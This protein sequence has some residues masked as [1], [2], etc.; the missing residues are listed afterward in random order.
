MKKKILMISI[1]LLNCLIM[2]FPWF[3]TIDG[4]KNIYGF[5]MLENPIAL[6]CL[7]LCFIGIWIKHQ[8]SQIFEM[9]GWIGMIMMQIYEFLTW[10]IRISGGSIDVHLSCQL[11]YSYFYL[12][13]F[14]S[15]ISC[16]IYKLVL[17]RIK[18]KQEYIVYV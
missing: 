16:V 11:A 7:I 2:W 15:M 17:N 9:I 18:N 5:I 12:A 1:L 8:Y 14:I 6:T 4:N 10:H 13:V 3:K